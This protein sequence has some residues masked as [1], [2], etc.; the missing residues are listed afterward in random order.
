[1]VMQSALYNT[2]GP[3]SDGMPFRNRSMEQYNTN[4][5][6][7]MLPIFN[8]GNIQGGAPSQVAQYQNPLF[9]MGPINGG[10]P[11]Q[12]ATMSVQPPAVNMPQFAGPIQGGPYTSRPITQTAGGY[13]GWAALKAQLAQQGFGGGY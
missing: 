10:A 11:Q 5:G 9:N 2:R 1:M 12:V 4:S 6:N 8:V 13:G 3:M 7:P